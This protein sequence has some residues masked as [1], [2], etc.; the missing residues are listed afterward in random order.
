MWTNISLETHAGG[1]AATH[2]NHQSRSNAELR[3]HRVGTWRCRANAVWAR[4]AG[5][6]AHYVFRWTSPM[7]HPAT[8]VHEQATL[9]A[10]TTQH[11]GRPL[12]D[13]PDQ[14]TAKG[15]GEGHCDDAARTRWHAP[16]DNTKYQTRRGRDSRIRGSIAGQVPLLHTISER[17]ARTQQTKFRRLYDAQL[18]DT[19]LS[20]VGR[21]TPAA[22]Q[23]LPRTPR[24]VLLAMPWLLPLCLAVHITMALYGMP[25]T[26][27]HH[28][29]PHHVPH[30][31]A[32]QQLQPTGAGHVRAPSAAGAGRNMA[33][34]MSRCA[35][36][37]KSAYDIGAASRCAPDTFQTI[38]LSTRETSPAIRHA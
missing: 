37:P 10:I 22:I 38:S 7:V 32:L 13:E 11:T 9:N 21:R 23:V 29:T 33:C 4:P 25:R 20:V 30:A 16:Q 26:T 28:S 17:T 15:R 8:V 24:V 2:T 27:P 3:A 34:I 35:L 31:N 1:T 36:A 19:V 6:P 5:S 12:L 18:P 14:K